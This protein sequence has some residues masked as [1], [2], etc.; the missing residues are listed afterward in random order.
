LRLLLG[1]G[2]L[3][4]LFGYF[5]LSPFIGGALKFF[6]INKKVLCSFYPAH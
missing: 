4:T 6:L 1:T 5:Y 2:I 3:L